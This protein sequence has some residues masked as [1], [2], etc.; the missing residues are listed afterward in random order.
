MAVKPG[1]FEVKTFVAFKCSTI[2]AYAASLVSA[3]M[4]MSETKP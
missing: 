1:H 2:D 3:G 4:T